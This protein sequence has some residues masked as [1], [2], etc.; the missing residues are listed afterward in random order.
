M[1]HYVQ[2]T[3]TKATPWR[4]QVSFFFFNSHMRIVLSLKVMY[5]VMYAYFLKDMS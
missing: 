5:D 1:L 2:R 3:N 4:Q